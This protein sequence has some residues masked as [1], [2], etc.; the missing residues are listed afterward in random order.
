MSNV[1]VRHHPSTFDIRYWIFV[2]HFHSLDLS[3]MKKIPDKSLAGVKEIAKRANVSLATVDRVIHNRTGVSPKTRQKIQA[4]IEELNYQPNVL[5]RRLALTA[6]GSIRMAILLPDIS[7][8]T[9]FWQAPLDGINRAEEEIRQYG[10]HIERY[11][12][13]QN[14]RLS[15]ARQVSKIKKYKPDGLLFTPV[16]PEES[17]QLIRFSEAQNIRCVLI[18]SDMPGF[19]RSCYIGPDLF[20]SGYLSAQLVSYCIKGNKSVLIANIAREID[21]NYAILHKEEGFRA[22]FKDHQIRNELLILNSNQT[23][24]TAVSAKL[25]RMLK[26]HPDIGAVF[27]TNSRVSVM[28]KCLEKLGKKDVILLGHDFT[29]DNVAYLEKGQIDF[30]ICEKPEEQ[31]YRGIISL[32]QQLVLSKETERI[33]LMP[34]DIITRHN[35]RYYRN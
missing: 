5:A 30:L 34:I 7:E 6:R 22:Y 32:F 2:I 24:H 17:A 15:F 27:V 35:Y 20:H 14:D 16:F 11:F 8:E 12:F 33:Y 3:V 29:K 26:K 19:E 18:N 28:A 1:E 13:D 10:I 9:E 25:Q 4:I 31:G 23:D 21:N